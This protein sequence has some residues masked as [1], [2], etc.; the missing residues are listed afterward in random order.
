MSKNKVNC[1]LFN[2]EIEIGY[3]REICVAVEGMLKKTA[4]RDDI[5]K[6]DNYEDICNSC[7]IHED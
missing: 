4:L 7:P 2:K 1:P 6:I 3:C 5:T